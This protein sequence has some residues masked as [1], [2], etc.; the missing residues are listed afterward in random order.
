MSV[1]HDGPRE[2]PELDYVTNEDGEVTFFAADKGLEATETEWITCDADGLV[3]P[4]D[5]IA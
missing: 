1:T 2:Q 5:V 3:V 4:E